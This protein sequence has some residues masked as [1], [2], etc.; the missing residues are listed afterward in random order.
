VGNTHQQ[1]TQVGSSGHVHDGIAFQLPMVLHPWRT[2]ETRLLDNRSA[3]VVPQCAC[4]ALEMLGLHVESDLRGRFRSR[5]QLSV[6]SGHTFLTTITPGRVTSRCEA[7]SAVKANG[8]TGAK[9]LTCRRQW[10]TSA[11][12]RG[13]ERAAPAWLHE[14]EAS[15]KLVRVPM[16]SDLRL[17]DVSFMHYCN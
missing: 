13:W 4:W 2:P 9:C 6:S 12:G 14:Q 16:C 10:Y 3:R 1:P 5:R 8:V 15:L 17:A 11:A 7:S